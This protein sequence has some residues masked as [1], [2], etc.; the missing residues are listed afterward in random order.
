MI[1][2][3]ES[4]Y[5]LTSKLN[6]SGSNHLSLLQEEQEM[7]WWHHWQRQVCLNFHTWAPCG[8]HWD[9][10][11]KVSTWTLCEVS[12]T[13]PNHT[14]TQKAYSICFNKVP[15]QLSDSFQQHKWFQSNDCGWG[16]DISPLFMSDPY[17]IL[18][19]EVTDRHA[20][21]LG[22]CVRSLSSCRVKV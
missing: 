14:K 4:Y 6:K 1:A 13:K 7:H 16:T 22:V 8:A 12:K 5:I 9:M 19:Q 17:T 18:H 20:L 11:P 10:K 15:E 21:K 2:L 3:T